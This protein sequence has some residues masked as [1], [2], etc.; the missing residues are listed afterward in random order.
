MSLYDLGPNIQIEYQT[1]HEDV[2]NDFYIP[3]LRNS[4]SFD[5]AVGFFSSGLLLKLTEGLASFAKNGGK[6]RL[7][8]SP[9]L[10]PSDYDAIKN[11]Y[12]AR[13]Y[14]TNKIIDD[15]DEFT[16]YEQRND[17][18]GLLA[19][20]ISSNLLEVKIAFLEEKNDKE[21]FHEKLGIMTDSYGNMVTF[22]GSSND[23]VNGF[24]N[25]Y[26]NI[27]VFCSWKSEGDDT[28]CS[29][30]K[31]RFDR[32]WNQSEKGLITIP[33][34]EVIKN[35]ILSYKKD[36]DSIF[37]VDEKYVENY[38]KKRILN[39]V[40]FP[41]LD[42]IKKN[43]QDL[44]Q[45]QYDAI[46]NWKK[47]NYIGIYDMATGTGKTYTACGSIVQ[48]FNDKKRLV[49]VIC[50]PFIHLAEQWGEEVSKFNIDPIIC[51]GSSGYE[52]DLKRQLTKFKQKRIDFVCA[53]CVNGSFVGDKIQNLLVDNLE[54]TLLIVDEAHNFGSYTLSKTLTVDYPYRLALSA[55]LERYGDEVGTKK[56]YDFF[57]KKCI[58]YTL[59][60]AIAEKK[61]TKYNYYPIPVYLDPDELDMYFEYTKIIQKM[62][63][64]KNLD[65]P[66]YKS[67]LLKRTKIISGAHNKLEA[68]Y[69]EL[70]RYKKER[71]ILIYCGAVKYG[72]DGYE[73]C[74]DEVSQIREIV[75]Y[76]NKHLGIYAHEFTSN[77]KKDERLRL[78]DSF[79]AEN[80]LQ[81]LVAIK[82]LDEGMN[83][84]A[85][86]TAF[87][88]ASSTNPKEYIQRRGRVL[89]HYPGKEFAE[90]YDFITLPRD[91]SKVKYL[92]KEELKIDLTLVKREF[93]R[94]LDFAKV[95][96]NSSDC[97]DFIA[98][99][100]EAYGLYV[101]KEDFDD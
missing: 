57:G 26:E 10:D 35:K 2:V 36:D 55:T 76:I 81:A 71:N 45:Y 100:K 101:I 79:K 41:T 9:R 24:I 98:R 31:M 20:M 14:L 28:R 96:K 12:D 5:R 48:L 29:L 80:G 33:F 89:R 19:Y 51:Y 7:I 40:K 22:T 16:E 25:N 64:Y 8:V 65:D 75:A 58:E 6:M 15:F 70:A 73:H 92:S 66:A 87:I 21:M 50:C 94:L 68:L 17:R 99:I 60:Q 86:K 46:N 93:V 97:N 34:P 90:I 44:H 84:P 23:T 82:C 77:E 18:Y 63:V 83:I 78:I 52:K 54:Y 42:L 43:G 47:N 62:S 37:E 61:L 59:E 27:D 13:E 69:N 72:E 91:L 53:I 30:K 56:L 88:L 3:C 67:M 39:N 4:V 74:N 85:I 32:M 95:A 1:L 38:K 11:G 49:V